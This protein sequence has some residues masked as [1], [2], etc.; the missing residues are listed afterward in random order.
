MT[1]SSSLSVSR[2]ISI[3][4]QACTDAARGFDAVHARHRVIN[5][6]DVGLC[7]QGGV[8]R[9]ISVA[10]FGFH[11]PSAAALQQSPQAAAENGMVIGDQYACHNRGFSISTR[12]GSSNLEVQKPGNWTKG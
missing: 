12:S 10:G 3:F 9:F 1:D 4:G 7:P 11:R 8:N 2:Q 6:C 5:D